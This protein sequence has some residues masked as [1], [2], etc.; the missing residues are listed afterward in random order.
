MSDVVPIRCSIFRGGTSKGV[1]FLDNDLPA[2]PAVRERVLL[3]V[4]GSPDIRQIDGLGG[5]T[6]QTSKVAIIGPSTRPDADV[7]Y[8]FGAISMP[9]PMVDWGGNCGNISSAVG[10]YA[11]DMGLVRAVEPMTTVRIH[12]TNTQKVIVAHVP[13]A[14]G[15]ARIDGDH[16]IPGVPGTAARILLD[17]EDPAGSVTGKLLPTGRP[18]DV[19]QLADGRR[20]EVSVVDAANPVAFLRASDLGCDGTELPLAIEANA[21][22]CAVQE[23]VRSIVAEMLGIVPDRALATKTSPGLPKVGYVAPPKAYVTTTGETVPADAMDLLGRVMSM[24][25][26]HRSYMT[27]G[28]IA[29]AA[30]AITPGTIV[31]QVTRPAG[32]RPETAGIRIAHPYGIMGTVC[33]YEPGELPRIA[34]IAVGRTARHILDGQVYARRRAFGG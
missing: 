16:A 18:V 10:P 27:T 20:L 17:F 19:V 11:I 33:T 2:D 21:D 31:H 26:A 23:E 32:E 6:S 9:E 22:L 13:V 28:G 34:A 8:T 12:N 24:Q 25:T 3:D 5:A 4:F 14:G 30:A 1:F 7:D 15:R 29:T